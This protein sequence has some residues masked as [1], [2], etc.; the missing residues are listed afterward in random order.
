MHKD[1]NL[2]TNSSYLAVAVIISIIII[3]IIILLLIWAFWAGVD[4]TDRNDDLCLEVGS[5]WTGRGLIQT[6]QNLNQ[7]AY[8]IDLI[9]KIDRINQDYKG[10]RIVEITYSFRQY[11]NQ[12]QVTAQGTN[13]AFGPITNGTISLTDLNDQA[14][15]QLRPLA[16]GN[17]EF[18]G[19]EFMDSREGSSKVATVIKLSKEPKLYSF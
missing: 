13:R 19:T 8:P 7:P 16:D 14:L 9:T 1:Q 17:L 10:N 4:H 11:N 5:K 6:S 2:V 18:S 12:G 15:I 3:V